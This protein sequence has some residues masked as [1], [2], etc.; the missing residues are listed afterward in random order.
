MR[1]PSG[2]AV[3]NP[4]PLGLGIDA[5]LGSILRQLHTFIQRHQ[6]HRP[7][8]HKR[9]TTG[10]QS[11]RDAVLQNHCRKARH[12]TPRHL[13]PSPG[14]KP[15]AEEV[16]VTESRALG[17]NRSAT[18]ITPEQTSQLKLNSM[19]AGIGSLILGG[20]CSQKNCRFHSFRG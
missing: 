20:C 3:V 14:K 16:G 10:T 4:T 7:Q 2:S 9:H 1:H 12:R 6:H 17:L 5:G 19:T 13:R 18:E 15:R 11:L 8:R